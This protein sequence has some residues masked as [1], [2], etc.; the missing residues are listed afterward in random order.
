MNYHYYKKL[1]PDSILV[2]VEEFNKQNRTVLFDFIDS[3]EYELFLSSINAN[4]DGYTPSMILLNNYNGR[5]VQENTIYAIRPAIFQSWLKQNLIITDN[6]SSF[7]IGYSI[8]VTKTKESIFN[9]SVSLSNFDT[10]HLKYIM[11]GKGDNLKIPI[12]IKK[13]QLSVTVRNVGQGNWNEIYYNGIVKFVYDAGAPMNAS[14]SEIKTIIGNRNTLYPISKPILILSHW[15]KDHYHS[16]IGMT[17]AELQNN[18][19]AFICRDRV[20]NLTS[21]T[22]FNR[23]LKAVGTKNTYTIPANKKINNGGPTFFKPH[24]PINNQIVLYNSQEHKNRNISGIAIA[25]K[26]KNSSIILPG[27]AHYE[28]ISRDI[29]PHLNYKHSHNLVVPH[30]GGKAGK[31]QYNL[32]SLTTVD[33]AVISVGTNHYGHPLTNYIA[34]L[35]ASGFT[36]EQTVKTKTDITITL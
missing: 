2:Y 7:L 3:D 33:K 5:T 24:T 18:F 29:L 17:D 34:F 15:D 19:S 30:H 1:F 4:I 35:K 13:G 12:H 11:Q 27:D 9:D 10:L 25:V 36:T 32:S 16:L 22:L 6:L 28:Q 31:Y 21:I 20:H 23:I 26:T 8:D 14:K